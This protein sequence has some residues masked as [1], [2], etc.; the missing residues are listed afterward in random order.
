MRMIVLFLLMVLPLLPQ[1][2]T[3][4]ID[5]DEIKPR[6]LAG[7]GNQVDKTRTVVN[8]SG[9]VI[10][11]SE[12][13]D[14]TTGE[15][16]LCSYLIK[17]NLKTKRVT[18]LFE[19]DIFDIA[20]LW[21]GDK[22]LLI[23]TY[24]SNEAPSRGYEVK[25]GT[26]NFD[27]KGK[28]TSPV[29]E[30]H[31]FQT[32]ENS[33]FYLSSLAACAGESEVLVALAGGFSQYDSEARFSGVKRY[34]GY[35]LRLDFDGYTLNTIEI[36]QPNGNNLKLLSF[37]KPLFTQGAWLVPANLCLYK[38]TYNADTDMTTTD[39]KKNLLYVY[40]LEE[41]QGNYTRQ[42]P[43]KE[44]PAVRSTW[45]GF[46]S[47]SWLTADETSSSS[48]GQNTMLV[49]HRQL[50]PDDQYKKYDWFEND[51]LL[52]TVDTRGKRKGRAKRVEIA[53]WQ[54]QNT[55]QEG[56][57]FDWATDR[58]TDVKQID[59]NYYFGQ[60]R[61]FSFM[62]PGNDPRDINEF[63]QN[64]WRLDPDSG[65]AELAATSNG[66]LGDGFSRTP[67]AFFAY[68]SLT[69]LIPLWNY[70]LGAWEIN[71]LAASFMP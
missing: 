15:Q 45:R 7:N 54:R 3:G 70:N 8:G 19:A 21:L 13:R 35:L 24:K 6:G 62:R 26:A 49:H 43:A 66:Y 42:R 25:M 63:Q 39:V 17:K 37:F 11:F 46:Q 57:I 33:Y 61:C 65:S 22:G 4:T 55:W 9:K 56:D 1:A 20:P 29:Y 16:F 12:F 68:K 14:N 27:A 47:V 59:G 53:A 38:S 23:F 31:S 71:L 32:L 50:L 30:M 2:Q 60:T 64:F 69:M 51:Y 41:G 40:R 10:A 44:K 58:L 36:V 28:L 34:A 18:R 48:S 52:I 5:I 67:S